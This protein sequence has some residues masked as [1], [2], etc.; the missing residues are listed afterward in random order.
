MLGI[1]DINGNLIS[2]DSVQNDGKTIVNLNVSG[3][4][5]VLAVAR[6]KVSVSA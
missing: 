1:Y 6:F 4:G 2:S 3:K 5:V